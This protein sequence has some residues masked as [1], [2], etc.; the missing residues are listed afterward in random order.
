M[1]HHSG[2][3][4]SILHALLVL[5]TCLLATPALAT[6]FRPYAVANV[7]VDVTADT[8]AAARNIA[9]GEAQAQALGMLLRRMTLKED[10]AR[11]P[12]LS[13]NAVSSLVQ[14]IEFADERYS[15]TRYIAKVTVS[16]TPSAIRALLRD[17]G[18]PF[19]EAPAE[20]ILVVPVYQQQAAETTPWWAAWA[21][22]DW[23]ENLL[24]FQLPAAGEVG[25]GDVH[26]P[27]TLDALGR[28]YGTSEVLVASAVL[29]TTAGVKLVVDVRRFGMGG[30]RTDRREFVQQP[31]EPPEALLMRAAREIGD[32]VTAEWKRNAMVG[33]GA[34]SE[35][36][37]VFDLRS[38]QE[39]VTVRDRLKRA[40]MVKT[41]VVESLNVNRAMISLTVTVPPA[42]LPGAMTQYGIELSQRG[43]DWHIAPRR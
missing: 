24:S 43:G 35:I 1:T 3:A 8:A 30:E 14:S 37:A 2:G 29:D 34:E 16:F 27:G 18:I 4:R 33:Q 13:G 40:P 38:L 41:A 32:D 28:R 19:A 15:T 25:A 26:Q 7:P 17:A 21:R 20:P 22:L 11:L 5:L 42:Q 6:E 23:Q 9:I 10:R 12:R 36:L 31:G 39:L